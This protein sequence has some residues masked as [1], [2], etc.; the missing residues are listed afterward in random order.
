[1]I[2]PSESDIV[3]RFARRHRLRPLETL[4][5]VLIVAG[6][7]LFP[8]YL[9]LGAQIL[10]TT[11]FGLSVDLVLGYAGIVTLGHAAFYGVGAYTAG[12]LAA[13]GIG[14]P[15]VGMLAAMAMAGVLG[16]ISGAIILRAQG[17][18][19]L[20]LTL[21]VCVML[22]E[23]A[24]KMTS[25]T[26]GADGLQG[27]DVS[28]VLGLFRFDL[29]GETAYWYAAA[30]LFI[31]WAVARTLV[32]SPFGRSLTGIREN[33]ARMHAIGTPVFW[34]LLTIYAISAAMAGAAGAIIADT[35]QL[36]ALNAL[37][38]DLSGLI[39][40]MVIFGGV[41][42]LYGAFVGVPLYMIAQD[43]FS[44]ID[45][46]YWYF[47]IGLLLVIVVL[48]ARG[49]ILGLTDLLWQRVQRRRAR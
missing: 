36:V 16:L 15:I 14:A 18:S 49:G 42:R 2:Q 22:Q 27:M 4:P 40:V 17:L 31:G 3:A 37:S 8:D 43:R 34:R 41:G 13:H 46:T 28:P 6:F 29:Y 12:Y 21:V 5:W 47:W 9:A 39:L 1:M 45:P 10:A 30:A 11:L 26:G 7:F 20:M 25:I 23:A 32:H 38:V 48:F 19:I 33:V 44:E 35:T 24:N